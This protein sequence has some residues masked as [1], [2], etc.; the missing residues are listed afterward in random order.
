MT[1]D[2]DCFGH[3]IK[4][5]KNMYIEQI[6]DCKPTWRFNGEYTEQK[7]LLSNGSNMRVP[8]CKTCKNTL[9]DEDSKEIMACVIRGWE[10]ESDELV[11]NKDK[12][13]WDKKKRDKYMEEYS[14][15]K[16]VGSSENIDK[17]VLKKKLKKFKKDK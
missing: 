10:K 8:M 9:T 6:I 7:F 15:L 13:N 3:C 2:F 12:K 16:I 14:K 5:H 11:K 17:D 1:I 4:C